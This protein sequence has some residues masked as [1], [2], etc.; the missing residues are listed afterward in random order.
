[1]PA[2]ARKSD[3]AKP[4]RKFT[5]K[6]YV[7][8]ELPPEGYVRLPTV[9]KVFPVSATSWNNGIRSGKYP[10]PVKLGP[11]TVAWRVEDIRALLSGDAA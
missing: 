10:A 4:K 7:P 5:P 2:T 1:M 8:H 11:R 6:T 9:L 3:K